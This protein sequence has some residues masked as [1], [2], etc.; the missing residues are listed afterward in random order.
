MANRYS[1]RNANTPAP[2]RKKNLAVQIILVIVSIAMLAGIL[3]MPFMSTTAYAEDNG[4]SVVVEK[5]EKGKLGE[6][7]TEAS[8]G[9]D[10]NHITKLAVLS[11]TLTAADYQAITNIPNLENI[12]LAG[13]ETED[14]V[15]PDYAIPSRNQLAYIS[16]PKNTVEIGEKAFSNNK[17]LIKVSMPDSV[18]IIG[19][20]AF[21]ACEA[22]S[23]IPVTENVTYIGEGAFRDCKAITE[24]T[25]PSNITE[26][27]A[28]TFSKCGFSEIIIGPDVKSI[29]DGAFAD[30]NNLKDIYV[31]AENAPS[32]A[33]S[34]V[35]QN[36]GA[37]IHV[38]EDSAESYKSWE[39][40][41]IKASGDL[42]GDYPVVTAAPATETAPAETEVV[43]A[44]E[45]A[46][47]EAAETEAKEEE[48]SAPEKA[49]TEA[50]ASE[51]TAVQTAA[52][53]GSQPN[54]ILIVVIVAVVGIG[55]GFG[56]AMLFSKIKK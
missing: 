20:Y 5:F 11:G 22:M 55:A 2:K 39:G 14:G 47:T 43:T 46:E 32:V 56:G 10:F 52:E 37:T 8:E 50:A 31:Y 24:F 13:C 41:N 35:F 17:K 38:Y 33:N 23:E 9:V 21:E 1:R 19:S 40:N 15:I 3:M 25:I 27:F 42:T 34:G 29:G 49:D 26:I 45:N 6:A 48:T 16:L 53:E 51:E 7:V 36:V 18:K 30:C 12:E 4:V 54:I 28:Y 44:A